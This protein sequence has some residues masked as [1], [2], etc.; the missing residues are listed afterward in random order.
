MTDESTIRARE[1]AQQIRATTIGVLK[2]H[3]NDRS[4]IEWAL[5]LN[6][7]HA[8]EQNAIRDLLTFPELKVKEPFRS[9]WFWLLESW[10]ARPRTHNDS[11]SSL[12]SI[13]SRA[14]AL[15]G[16]CCARSSTLFARGRA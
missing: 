14:E 1:L 12:Y 15:T 16:K 3:L 10:S 8:E 6:D 11:L 5:E 4:S 9:A 13:L 2:D 7:N